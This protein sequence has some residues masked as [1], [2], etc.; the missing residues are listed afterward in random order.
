MSSEPKR[1][2]IEVG[3]TIGILGGGQLGRMLA[4]AARQMG[5]NI[6]FLDPSSDAPCS[7][8]ADKKIIAPYDDITSVL[9]LGAKSNVV[10]YEFENIDVNSV[11]ALE[12]AGYQVY[13][14]SN[15]LKISQHRILEK[16]FVRSIGIKTVPFYP[17]YEF[18]D[19]EKAA[20]EVGF[21]VL[22]KTAF[23]G[24]DGKGQVKIINLE[25]AQQVFLSLNHRTL[26]W[27]KM[28][29]FTKELA[30]ICVRD[31]LGQIITYPVTENIHI[32]NILDTTIVPARIPD[33][34]AKEAADI[35]KKIA[36]ELNIVGAFCVEMFLM[37]NNEILVNE[38]APRPHNSGH[39]TIDACIS[40][41]FEQQ[42]RAICGLPLGSPKMLTK[43]AVMVN[44]L[45]DHKGDRF[46]GTTEILANSNVCLHLY[47]KKKAKPK[48]KMGHFTVLADDIDT[49][50]K[51]A[52]ETRK[53]L[54]WLESRYRR[55]K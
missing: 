41:Q 24:Y 38:I 4:I 53:K 34:V 55:I 29:N 22:L 28:V 23:G 1:K 52:E 26:I 19:V 47:G 33:K 31:Q 8:V 43:S 35:A 20:K 5:Y 16:E 49:A 46:F 10:T 21:P 12:K 50:L 45:G 36:Q 11:I 39:Y 51:I 25:Q 7:A 15:V 44:I 42:F 18:D 17:L 48:R 30:I 6:I 9:K 14:N 13:P 40:S 37:E 2:S 32:D 27:E 3:G 54:C